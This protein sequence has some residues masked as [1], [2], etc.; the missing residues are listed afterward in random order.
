[1]SESEL[2]DLRAQN[3][4]LRAELSRLERE[5]AAERATLRSAQAR[6]LSLQADLDEAHAHLG[7]RVRLPIRVVRKARRVAGRSLRLVGL[8]R[9]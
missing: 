9:G 3:T 5:R 2:A 1:M 6:L 4:Q 7:A 8:R